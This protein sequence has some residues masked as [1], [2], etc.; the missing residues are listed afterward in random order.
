M[1]A[2]SIPPIIMATLMFYVGFYHFLIYRRQISNRENLTF[3]LSCFGVGMYAVC[4]AGLYNASSPEI[5][6]EW[7]R[8]QVITLAVLAIVLLWFIADYTNRT[9]KKIVIGFTVYFLFAAV[10][11]LIIRSNLT[12]TNVT[13]IKEIQLPI[14]YHIRYNEM[15]PG[16]LTDFQ[17]IVGL[18]YFIYIF[19]V[20]L[21]FYKS[22]NKEKGMPLLIAMAV[23]FAGNLNDTL[24]SSGFYDFIYILEYS[25]IGMILVFTLF[26]TNNVIKAGEIK[27]AL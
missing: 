7:Q 1:N 9:N 8:F 10:S 17:G 2:I 24:V 27:V 15:V 22:G 14:G 21:K 26:F 20:S 4:C 5:G 11:G 13:S 6:V 16:V 19:M 3:A 12:W 18:I 23:L 25:Y